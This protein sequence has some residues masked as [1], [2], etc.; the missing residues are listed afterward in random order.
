MKGLKG[1]EFKSLINYYFI[2]KIHIFI[3]IFIYILFFL[4]K[5]I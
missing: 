1:F 5:Y 4:Y 2:I 3:Y